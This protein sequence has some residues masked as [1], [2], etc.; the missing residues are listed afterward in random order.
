MTSLVT[1]ASGF[2]GS[3]VA[4]MLVDRG[5]KI[6][7]LVRPQSNLVALEG[8][9][10]EKVDGD[11][12]DPESLA[13]AVE[14]VDRVFHV[15]ADYRLGA[16]HPQEIYDSNVAGTR[17]LLEAAARAGVQR[18]IVTS[19]VATIAVDRGNTL[20]N[21]ATE[22]GIE[23][24]IGHYK[25][26][27]FLAEKE[28]FRA[29]RQGIPVV[30]VNPTTPVGPGD[31]KPTPTGRI[32]V[33]FLNGR[34]PAYV[35]AGLNWVPVEDVAL[36]HWIAA[37][38]GLVGKRYILGGR[39]MLLKEVLDT[40]ARISGRPSPRICLPHAVA[41]AAGYADQVFSRILNRQPRIPLEGVRMARHN[42]FVDC[43]RAAD[44]LG[45][46]AGPVE[47]A[48]ERA[49][50]WY[51]RKGYFHNNNAPPKFVRAA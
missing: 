27:K 10:V 39:N 37:E 23:E 4:R 46:K 38:R 1:G 51:E 49:V 28:A 21:E 13:C 17:N 34:M 35:E 16:R 42:M 40:L 50:A 45:F 11:L 25:R 12:R 29:A 36:G 41:M 33:D 30:V 22:A 8:V 15:A 48:F 32:I 44:E 47:A 5:E 19:S 31:W 3:H 20:P 18:I 14:G 24:M 9:P 43:S 6:R 26:S 7:V 2:V